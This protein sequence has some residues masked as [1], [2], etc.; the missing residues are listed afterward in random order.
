MC[1]TTTSVR[2]LVNVLQS[3]EHAQNLVLPLYD[4]V[5]ECVVPASHLE[6]QYA[7]EIDYFHTQLPIV[8]R[9]LLE[10]YEQHVYA[11]YVTSPEAPS[12]IS[13]QEQLQLYE[14][15]EKYEISKQQITNYQVHVQQALQHHT[16]EVLKLQ[17]YVDS[18]QYVVG[19][20]TSVVS[21]HSLQSKYQQRILDVAQ[22]FFR[23]VQDFSK[24]RKNL[25]NH[26]HYFYSS[27]CYT[28]TKGTQFTNLARI[29]SI[30]AWCWN[31]YVS[32]YFVLSFLLYLFA[33]H[34]QM[35]DR[36]WTVLFCLPL[37][38]LG[39]IAWVQKRTMNF[40]VFVAC[41]AYGL[42]YG[43][44]YYLYSSWY[45][46]RLLSWIGTQMI[47]WILQDKFAL[48]SF[49][50]RLGFDSYIARLV[51]LLCLY[52]P[53]TVWMR[54]WVKEM[55]L[56]SPRSW[57]WTLSTEMLTTI[58]STIVESVSH[59]INACKLLTHSEESLTDYVR[60]RL[61]APRPL[62]PV[63][64]IRRWLESSK[65][66]EERMGD[67]QHLWDQFQYHHSKWS[68][69]KV[70]SDWQLWLG[71]V[72]YTPLCTTTVDLYSTVLYLYMT[73][74]LFQPLVSSI[75]S[76]TFFFISKVY[77]MVWYLFKGW[78]TDG[79][80]LQRLKNLHQSLQTHTNR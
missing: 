61:L 37:L 76:I 72:W 27:W 40:V 10:H 13:K 41:C 29:P 19:S 15:V 55:L 18:L 75:L 3:T 32:Y 39:F 71:L 45:S 67:Y 77:Q 42:M 70:W 66:F 2:T 56:S 78:G 46:I 25:T 52:H 35:E 14:W 20:D 49:L 43:V 5:N 7:Y 8:Y 60:H 24:Q 28:P 74:V 12:S 63:L 48:Y 57:D 26:L 68:E 21:L 69:M 47:G 38:L 64:P 22:M 44:D 1:S 79:I 50:T 17:G 73:Y 6:R 34:P 9:E 80:D 30:V 62:P 53:G 51:V 59:F 54:I 31:F 23:D 65:H 36:Y 33:Q 11:R 16:N 4:A 58:V